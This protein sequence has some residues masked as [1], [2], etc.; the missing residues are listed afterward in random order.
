[1]T[2]EGMQKWYTDRK[3]P[4]DGIHPEGYDQIVTE[5]V[6]K[7][8]HVLYMPPGYTEADQII[9]PALDAVW[10]GDQTAEE[11][12]KAAVPEANKVL[13]AAATA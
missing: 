4:G 6:P 5:Y 10:I 8:G 3:A 7:Y 11:A 2:S 1:M 13:Q 9:T 12:M